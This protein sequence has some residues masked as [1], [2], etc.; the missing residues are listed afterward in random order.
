[1]GAERDPGETTTY[2]TPPSIRASTAVRAAASDVRRS[3]EVSEVT[4][5]VCHPVATP[6]S[7]RCSI[8]YS[9]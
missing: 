6:T 2:W 5:P 9:P 7:R 8:T 3:G 1:M 4:E